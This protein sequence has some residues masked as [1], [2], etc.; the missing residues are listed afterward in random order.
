MAAQPPGEALSGTVAWRACDVWTAFLATCRLVEIATGKEI[1]RYDCFHNPLPADAP[2]WV[3]LLEAD[4]ANV[5]H[6]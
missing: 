4:G 5:F 2:T 3:K 6:D 1:A